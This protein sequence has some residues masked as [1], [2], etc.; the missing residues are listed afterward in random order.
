MEWL[1]PV[2]QWISNLG[3][4][5]FQKYLAIYLAGVIL[6]AGFI[7]YRHYSQMAK[8]RQKI[9]YVNGLRL[10]TKNILSRDEEVK[11]Q[12]NIVDKA[13]KSR[14]NFKLKHWFEDVISKQGL[15][16]NLQKYNAFVSS[17]EHLR[18]QGYSEVRIEASLTGL[19]TRQLVDLLAE[20]E[21]YDIIYIKY[22]E[23]NRSNKMPVIDVILT[24]AT[25]QLDSGEAVG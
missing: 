16:N 13:L 20:I 3:Q 5:E 8:L 2:N 25:L 7:G 21:K 18:S 10:D 19:N 24:I 6:I 11:H 17:L 15:H 1:K 9:Q 12:K 22:L 14:H 4:T 23:I